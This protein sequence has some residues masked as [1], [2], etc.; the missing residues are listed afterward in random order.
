MIWRTWGLPQFLT[1][2]SAPEGWIDGLAGPGRFVV[3][4]FCSVVPA[5]LVWRRPTSFVPAVGLSLVLFLL[6]SP[7]FGMQYLSWSL[8]AAYLVGTIPATAYNL[9]AS[10]FVLNVYSRWSGGGAPWD[11]YEGVAKFPDTWALRLMVVSWLALAWVAVAGLRTALR[12]DEE[13]A[14]DGGGARV[15]LEL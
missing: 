1:W 9:A 14:A 7:A 15:A 5:V 2:A 12:P 3:L 8:A 11:W 13:P 4:V 6:L 10:V